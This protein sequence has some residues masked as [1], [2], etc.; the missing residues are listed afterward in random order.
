M[1]LPELNKKD[2]RDILIIFAAVTMLTVLHFLITDFPLFPETTKLVDNNREYTIVNPGGAQGID[3]GMF[4]QM[5]SRDS[6]LIIDTRDREPFLKGHIPRA[7]NIPYEEG[8]VYM[9]RLE[10]M[11]DVQRVITYCDGD[12]CMSSVDL[13][14][15]LVFIFPEVYY[16][17]GGWDVWISKENPIETG[18]GR[19]L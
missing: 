18:K 14:E 10:Q 3:Y 9:S 8:N 11:S 16:F 17:F 12:D 7:V 4:Q 15:K 6:T 5:M 2:F 19:I 1:Q 13:A